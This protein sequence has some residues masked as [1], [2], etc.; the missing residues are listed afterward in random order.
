MRSKERENHSTYSS[1]YSKQWALRRDDDAEA[2][3]DLVLLLLRCHASSALRRRSVVTVNGGA[4]QHCVR[5]LVAHN[6]KE[7]QR[8]RKDQRPG[9]VCT[10]LQQTTNLKLRPP[11]ASEVYCGRSSWKKQVCDTGSARSGRLQKQNKTPVTSR[12]KR[13]MHDRVAER[14]TS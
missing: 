3:L 5:D 13:H 9:R 8:Q 14:P 6:L 2:A 11:T 1:T 7:K 12:S 4:V 10:S